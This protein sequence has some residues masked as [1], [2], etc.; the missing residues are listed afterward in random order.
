MLVM[1]EYEEELVGVFGP[2]PDWIF[3]LVEDRKG[4]ICWRCIVM[5]EP[6]VCYEGARPGGTFLC[7]LPC[8]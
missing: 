2:S 6:F 3:S 8:V 7:D 4:T 1:L 5:W